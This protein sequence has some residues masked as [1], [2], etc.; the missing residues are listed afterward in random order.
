MSIDLSFTDWHRQRLGIRDSRA[1][2]IWVNCYIQTQLVIQYEGTEYWDDPGTSGEFLLCVQM[3]K[4]S[5]QEEPNFEIVIKWLYL[6][7]CF[8]EN[9]SNNRR[10]WRTYR[11]TKS[12]FIIFVLEKKIGRSNIFLND[13]FQIRKLS[14]CVNNFDDKGIIK[15]RG[16]GEEKSCIKNYVQVIRECV[17]LERMWHNWNKRV[18]SS[19]LLS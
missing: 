12:L 16:R 14:S 8:H 3:N 9:N 13:N 4:E 5:I 11:F 1:M 10:N 15:N 18:R 6:L 2:E 19:C 7:K 17:S